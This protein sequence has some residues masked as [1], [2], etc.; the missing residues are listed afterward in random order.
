MEYLALIMGILGILFKIISNRKK[1]YMKDDSA[2]QKGTSIG[3]W[4]FCV[5]CI[6][7]GIL[8]IGENIITFF[9]K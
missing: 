6:I 3:T 7:A 4:I 9:T 8:G 1:L 5:F 2:Y